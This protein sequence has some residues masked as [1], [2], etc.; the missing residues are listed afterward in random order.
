MKIE[1]SGQAVVS[2]AAQVSKRQPRESVFAPSVCWPSDASRLLNISAVTLWRWE[3]KGLLPE[4]DVHVGN[5]SGWRPDT[6][7]TNIG[8]KN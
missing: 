1:E 2:P 6:L 3:R 8:H 5:R 4:R 7:L